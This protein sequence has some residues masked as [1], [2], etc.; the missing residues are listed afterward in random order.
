MINAC[1]L[2]FLTTTSVIFLFPPALPVDGATMNYVCVVIGVVGIMSAVVWLM[3]G[4]KHFVGPTELAER[5]E[6]GRRSSED[7]GV[8][9]S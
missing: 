3:D 6:V 4:R 9:G 8:P 5:L 2:I 7:V 1:S